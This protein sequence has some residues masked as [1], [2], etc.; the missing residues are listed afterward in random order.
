VVQNISKLIVKEKGSQ[1]WK[2]LNVV[3]FSLSP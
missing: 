1:R 2:E 3:E